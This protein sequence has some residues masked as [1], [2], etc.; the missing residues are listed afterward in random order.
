MLG[1]Q[2][3]LYK[4]GYCNIKYKSKKL[5]LHIFNKGLKT[6]YGNDTPQLQ[7]SGFLWRVTERD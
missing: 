4:K 1:A 5:E 7:D 6:C 3:E 2:W